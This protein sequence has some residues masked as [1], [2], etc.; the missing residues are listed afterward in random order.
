MQ[1][2]DCLAKACML[3]TAAVAA[4][5][6]WCCHVAVAA[7][8]NDAVSAA[9]VPVPPVISPSAAALLIKLTAWEQAA[10]VAL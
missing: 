8:T 2:N 3:S 1:S 4:P 10:A 7:S 5:S 9:D 6:P